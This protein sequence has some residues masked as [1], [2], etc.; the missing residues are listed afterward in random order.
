MLRKKKEGRPLPMTPEMSAW[1]KEFEKMSISE[2]EQKLR[3]LGLGDED[4][5]EF[6]EHFR[7]KRNPKQLV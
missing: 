4:L 2:H 3:G 1:E 6:K 7:Q 5:E